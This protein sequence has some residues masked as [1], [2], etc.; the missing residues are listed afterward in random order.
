MNRT[1]H[2]YL[3]SI[4]LVLLSPITTYSYVVKE[5]DTLSSI[6]R[7]YY[8][9]PAFGPNNGVE[10]LLQINKNRILNPS[11][12]K[13]GT[14]I[15]LNK[16]YLKS[17]IVDDMPETEV[18]RLETEV[19]EKV[20]PPAQAQNT[21]KTKKTNVPEL[22]T[23][24][25]DENPFIEVEKYENNKSTNRKVN[26]LDAV[27][28]YVQLVFNN[29][30]V[31]NRT[32]FA[33]FNLATST[34]TQYGLNYSK[35]LSDSLSLFVQAGLNQFSIPEDSNLT[36]ALEK[37]NKTQAT[38]TLGGNYLFTDNNYFSLIGHYRP[39]YYLVQNLQGL[40]SLDYAPSTSV[41]LETTNQFYNAQ[42]V[43]AG[44]QFGAEYITNAKISGN[45][46]SFHLGLIYQ[47]QFKAKDSAQI[48]LMY[49]QAN[50]DSEAYNIVSQSV[51]LNFA[52][53][54]PY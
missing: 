52:Y 5:G 7:D 13:P 25:T 47:Q 32:T 43:I 48:K 8:T 24:E 28:V 1:I 23:A 16:E 19:A 35:S 39:H 41:T 34:E 45:G 33:T 51:L 20:A 26:K 10:K 44:A 6:V 46:L 53:Q 40:L 37:A 2:L 36:P 11:V 54:L 12:L 42:E 38:A 49:A 21:K 14:Q 17:G 9:I 31:K 50:L 4:S 15:K 18:D 3:F 29:L 27:S 30:N 22:A